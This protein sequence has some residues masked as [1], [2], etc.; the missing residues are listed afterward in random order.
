MNF[1]ENDPFQ[2]TKCDFSHDLFYKNHG[3][4]IDFCHKRVYF[5][6]EIRVG[7]L[8]FIFDSS[9]FKLDGVGGRRPRIEGGGRMYWSVAWGGCF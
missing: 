5:H 7:F 2:K 9:C 8:N 6:M 1:C 4:L 3:C